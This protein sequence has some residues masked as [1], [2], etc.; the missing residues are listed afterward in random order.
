MVSHF[1]ADEDDLNDMDEPNRKPTSGKMLL[2]PLGKTT[3][4]DQK[5][6]YDQ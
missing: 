3:H 4:T 5:P 6:K 1:G 2:K